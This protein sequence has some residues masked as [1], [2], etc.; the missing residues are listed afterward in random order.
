MYFYWERYCVLMLASKFEFP[1]ESCHSLSI[2][3]NPCEV[4][5][6]LNFETWKVSCEV[7]FEIYFTGVS[8]YA[9]K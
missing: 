9:L 5:F 3:W 4:K 1:D 6:Q 8:D 2:I 7:K